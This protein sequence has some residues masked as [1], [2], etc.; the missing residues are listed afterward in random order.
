MT[1]ENIS[2]RIDQLFDD[3]VITGLAISGTSVYAPLFLRE[4]GTDLAFDPNRRDYTRFLTYS[5]KLLKY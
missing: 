3:Q 4:G 1:S 2:E 5:Y